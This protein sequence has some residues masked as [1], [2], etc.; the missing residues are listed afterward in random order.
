MT[1]FMHEQELSRKTFLKGGGALIVGFSLAGLGAKTAKA[2]ESPFASNGPFDQYS[3]DSWITINADNT[4][5]IKTGGV[6]QGTGSETG[7]LMIAG[8]ELN[9]DLS[10]LVFVNAD[11]DLTP[12]TGVKAASNTITNAGPGVRAAAAW[13]GQTL[14]GLASTQLGVPASQLSVSKGVVSGGGKTATYG[15]LLGGK[16]FNVQMPAT[17]NMTASADRFNVFNFTGGIRTG[18]SPAKPVSEYKLVGTSPQRIDIPQIVVGSTTYVHNVRVPGMLHG[19]VVRPRGQMVYGFGAPIVSIDESSIK[20]L[21]NVRVVRKGD[22][23]GVVAPHEYDAIQAAAQLKVKWADP[24]AVLPGSGDEF[25]GMRALDSAG[26][27]VQTATV[28]GNVDAALGSAAH[29][30]SQSYGWP[31]TNHSPIGPNATVADVRPEGARIFTWTQDVYKTRAAVAPV[32]GIPENRVR[33]THFAGG[34]TYGYNQYVDVAQAAALMSQ[35]VGAPVRVQLMRWDEIGW[36]QTAPG[37]LFDV[38]AG[39]DAK[40]NIVGFDFTQFYPQYR[41]ETVQTTAELAGIQSIVPSAA[42]GTRPMTPIYN[43]ANT[44]YLLKSLPLKGNWIKADWM[45][46]GSTPHGN[47]AIEQA[48]DEL[49][50]AAGIDPVAFR[51]QNVTQGEA[52]DSLLAVLDAVTRAAKWQPRVMASKLSDANVVT[53][54]G[55]AWNGAGTAASMKTAAVADITVNKKTGKVTVGHVYQAFSAGLAVYPGGIENQLVGGI[56]QILSRFLVEQMRYTKKQVTSVDFVSYP[57]LRFK[58]SP[59]ITPIIIQRT[60]MQ[61]AGVGEPVTGVAPAAVANAFFDATGVRLRTAPFTPARVRAA[62]KAAGVA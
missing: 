2:A 60:D 28:V 26:K 30:V 17:Y 54:R 38:R 44:R 3:I 37:A 15:Q 41:G 52:K 13:A 1:G 29:V 6:L 48:I 27:S 45:R 24:P 11:T 59:K 4:A 51:M 34:G 18:V 58:D 8:E 7:L 32:L 14:L 22:F 19:R 21:P 36:D 47:F 16:L 57:I 55:F 23:L 10:Q 5:S 33:V 40:G 50:T 12:I 61:P 53:G 43:I 9:M 46:H 39:V 56:T 35:L 20:H 31:T 62:L 49:A 25:K 42:A